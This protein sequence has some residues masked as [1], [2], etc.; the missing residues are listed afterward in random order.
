MDDLHDETLMIPQ[1]YV[2]INLNVE[3]LEKVDDLDD[4]IFCGLVFASASIGCVSNPST[5]ANGNL[6]TTITTNQ[7]ILSTLAKKKD[8]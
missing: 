7:V 4:S 5:N 8:F 3:F 6:S 1:A 2:V